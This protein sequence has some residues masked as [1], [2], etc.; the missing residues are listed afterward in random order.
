MFRFVNRVD[1]AGKTIIPP[2]INGHVH[3][4][5]PEN[6][7]ES[8]KA[9]V[10]GNLD[11]HTAD[12]FA[13]NLRMFNDSI[14]FAKYFSANAGA[15]VA[16][17]HGTQY[18]IEVPTVNDSVDGRQFVIDRIAAKADYI[19]ILK[20]PSMAMIDSEQTSDVIKQ[21]HILN[22]IAV[23]HVSKLENA[24]EL[25]SQNVDGFVHVWYDKLASQSLLDE[26]KSK[27]V[28]L[29]PTLGVTQE[30]FNMRG[31]EKFIPEGA[32]F[33]KVL[34]QVKSAYETGIK[35][36]CGTD[37]PNF[38][39]IFSDKIYDEMLLLSEAGLSNE[40]VIQ[41]A[42]V[43]IYEAFSLEGFSVLEPKA[44]A[45]FIM[46]DENPIEDIRHLKSNRKV[47]KAG[48]LVE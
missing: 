35:I 34:L 6:L 39:F 48:E 5:F 18:G 27:Q 37:A 29:M 4:W 12:H 45:D 10:F 42:T 13:N 15:T 24:Q 7:K 30:L 31:A 17:G 8:L 40:A 36:L 38:F 43:N 11:M 25:V 9:G 41:A 32:T 28:F 23:A 1:G 21:T 2:L 26:M 22:K 19:K 16:G 14:S 20:E 44:N 47:F 3:I 33:D 46:F